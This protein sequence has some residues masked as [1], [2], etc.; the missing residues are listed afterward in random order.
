MVQ[1]EHLSFHAAS[2]TD[3]SVRLLTLRQGG[4][5]LITFQGGDALTTF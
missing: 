1:Y 3:S 5:A 2:F 4:D